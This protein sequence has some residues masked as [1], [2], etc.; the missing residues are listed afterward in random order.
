M[1][2]LA[3]F[4]GDLSRSDGQ[5]SALR[6]KGKRFRF[7][8][9]ADSRQS[10]RKAAGQAS[11]LWIALVVAALLLLQGKSIDEAATLWGSKPAKAVKCLAVRAGDRLFVGVRR[12]GSN[13]C[14]L[15]EHED[16]ASGSRPSSA[17]VA[18]VPIA[19]RYAV[20]YASLARRAGAKRPSR[21][22]EIGGVTM[23]NSEGGGEGGILA[24]KWLSRFRSACGRASTIGRHA[25]RPCQRG[26]GLA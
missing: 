26:F 9:K 2:S 10:K 4:T 23:P 8:G 15:R 21:A 1:L 16:K 12:L 11:D 3:S 14:N 18:G 20:G 5:P 22:S 25:Q 6:G 19:L 7:A 13:S 17:Y 24:S